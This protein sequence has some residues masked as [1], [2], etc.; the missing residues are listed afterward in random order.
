MI[1]PDVNVLI[2]AFRTDS[3]DHAKY[4][5]W[6]ESVINGSS[7]CGVHLRCSAASCA[8]VRILTLPCHE[9]LEHAHAHYPDVHH[10]HQ[11]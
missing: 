6:L 4:K 2:Y 3:E 5:V 7:A 10:R 1:L 9:P 11:H 8:F